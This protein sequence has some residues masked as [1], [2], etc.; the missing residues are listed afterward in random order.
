MSKKRTTSKKRMSKKRMSRKRM[1]SKKRMA[2]KKRMSKK[3]MS[4]RKKS[5]SKVRIP[6][7]KGKLFG[8]H[9]DDLARDRRSLLKKL[10]RSKKAT[11]SEVIKRLNALVI[12]NKRKHPETSKRVKRD[13]DY[14]ERHMGKYRLS[15]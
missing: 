5:R 1:T 12:Y 11:F 3:L 4:K 7:T 10:I 8:Y 6:V 13:L 9:I 15:K 14:I 2:S